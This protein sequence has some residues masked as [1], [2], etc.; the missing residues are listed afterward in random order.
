MTK[1]IYKTYTKNQIEKAVK[2]SI[3]WRQVMEILNPTA[4][5]SSS[6][7][8]IKNKAIKFGIDFSHFLGQGWAIGKVARNKK[9]SSFYLGKKTDIRGTKLKS[10]LFEEGLKEKKCEN[11]KNTDWLGSMLVLELHHIDCNPKNNNIENLKILCPNCHSQ[12]HYKNFRS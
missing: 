12:E 11:C 10:L 5:Y 2:K 9:T 8:N 3:S 7:S 4:N 6:Q 1:K